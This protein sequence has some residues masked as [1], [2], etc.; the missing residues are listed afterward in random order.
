MATWLPKIDE[1]ADLRRLKTPELRELC[2]ELREE[3]L[4]VTALNGGHLASS[5]GAV[6]LVVAL[7]YV[8]DTPRDRLVFDVGHQAYAHKLLTGRRDQFPT[9]RQEGGLSGFLRR[10]ESPFDAFG[11]GH[12]STAIS[13][14]LG[15]ALARDRLGERYRVLAVTGDGSMTGGLCYEALNNLGNLKTDMVVLL[16]DNAMS[17]SRN[18]GAIARYF[19]RIVTTPFYNE[20]HRELVDLIMRLPAGGRIR[21]LGHKLEESLKGLILPGVLFEELGVRY[22]GPIDGHDLEALIATLLKV[23][24]LQGPLLLHVLTVKG[25]GRDYSESD[26]ITWHSPPV[27]P[28]KLETG[29][30]PPK[31]PGPPSYSSVFVDTLRELARRDRRLVALTAAMLEGTGLTSFQAEFPDRTFDV[32]IAEAHA[33]VCAAGMAC[34]GLRPFVCIY[35]TFLQRAVDPVIHDVALQ[36]LPVVLAVDRAG[37]VGADGPT[38]H[39][40]FDLAYLR[41]IPNLVVMAPMD[42]RELRQMTYTAFLH[43]SG[44]IALRFPRG[45]ASGAI[46]L[47]EPLEALPIGRAEVLADGEAVCLI[48]LGPMAA[49][50]IKAAAI[51]AERGV[52]P[53]VVNARFVK[54][55]DTG[56]LEN[57]A[58]RYRWLVTIEDHVAAGGFG[59]AVAEALAPLGV[60]RP[61]VILGLPD[62]FL[63]HGS[64]DSLYHQA[65]LSPEAIA[66]RVLGLIAADADAEK[67]GPAERGK[68]RR[69]T[70][71]AA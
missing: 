63:P 41:M 53:G 55:L 57:L 14:A 42:E 3:I 36:N 9:L 4:R 24:D 43:E 34:D 35:S 40:A 32:G 52:R 13:A 25:K 51:L 38:H 2:A 65:G 5:L 58:R 71:A 48:G 12:A 19:N 47:D 6:E 61:P 29:E 20:R 11:A 59:S 60:A 18:T 10:A 1:P 54:P 64:P 22:L 49:Q 46:P 21:R 31:A 30:T 44:P 17:I 67:H 68:P 50:A 8:F 70:S 15:M 66:E 37:L 16:N 62:R 33:V 56:L 7:H 45:K 23:R 69:R 39:G 26:P 27:V 28:F